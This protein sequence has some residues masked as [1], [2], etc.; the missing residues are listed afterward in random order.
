MFPSLNVF[1]SEHER[2][3]ALAHT[4]P[5]HQK[6][7]RAQGTLHEKGSKPASAASSGE[8]FD[9]HDHTPVS[10]SQ[11]FAETVK[12]ARISVMVPC[13][14]IAIA[15]QVIR[16]WRPVYV[17]RLFDVLTKAEVQSQLNLRLGSPEMNAQQSPVLDVTMENTFWPYVNMFVLFTFA[18][19]ILLTCRDWLAYTMKHRFRKEVRVEVF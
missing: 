8:L 11:L 17:G 1:C 13:M 6:G 2:L 7:K 15:V 12:R 9:E 3:V 5:S 4:L 16:I 18:E 14:L 10:I 19:Y